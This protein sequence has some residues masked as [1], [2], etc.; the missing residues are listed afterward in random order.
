[1]IRGSVVFQM[2]NELQTAVLSD[3]GWSCNGL[4]DIAAILNCVHHPNQSGPAGGDP[5]Y[6]AVHEAAK[7]L[8]GEPRVLVSQEEHPERVY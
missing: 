7:F 5:Y 8:R 6:R 1:M 3:D 4:D 2:F